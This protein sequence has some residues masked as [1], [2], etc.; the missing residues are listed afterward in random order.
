MNGFLW[1]EYFIF[2]GLS[3]V[4]AICIVPYALNLIPPEQRQKIKLTQPALIGVMVAQ[5]LV[6]M[7]VASLIGM[8][9][10][11]ATGLEAPVIAALARGQNPAEPVRALLPPALVLGLLS[12]VVLIVLEALYYQ[13]R[14][15]DALKKINHEAGPVKAFLA[16]FY[17]GI[18]EEILARW[19]V[20]SGLAWILGR[21]WTG[22]DGLPA[23]G[24]IWTANLLAA[25]LFGLGHLPATAGKTRL[26]PLIVGRAILLNGIAGLAFGYLFWQ[27]GLE[28]AI[29]AHFL[30]DLLIHIALP[31]FQARSTQPAAA[32]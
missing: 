17:G 18:S 14:L 30:L 26:T 31:I 9:A 4:G 27:Y 28:A 22:A 13:P 15:P 19:F 10:A 29:L 24:A 21:F 20:M 11:S 12:G 2:L 25:V 8:L 16:S 3:L 7:G 6:L 32:A 1:S 5:N 23:G